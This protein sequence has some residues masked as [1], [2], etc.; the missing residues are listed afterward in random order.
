MAS[1]LTTLPVR[2]MVAS[3][4]YALM[5]YLV[6]LGLP[7]RIMRQVLQEWAAAVNV[8]LTAGDYDLLNAHLKTTKG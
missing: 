2:F 5:N 4:K 8:S 1:L 6:E 3:E 7:A